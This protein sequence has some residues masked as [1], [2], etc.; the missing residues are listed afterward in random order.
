MFTCTFDF[1]IFLIHII[2][3]NFDKN[4]KIIKIYLKKKGFFLCDFISHFKKLIP[5]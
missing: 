5:W 1:S 2:F 3:E 4:E